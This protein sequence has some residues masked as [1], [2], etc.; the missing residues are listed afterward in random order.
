MLLPWSI[1]IDLKLFLKYSSKMW[2]IRTWEQNEK[3]FN[4]I[5]P[6][7]SEERHWAAAV[8][9]TQPGAGSECEPRTRD[10][11]QC[12]EPSRTRRRSVCWVQ[13]KGQIDLIRTA[14]DRL[15][16]GGVT[17]F[18]KPGEDH[19]VCGK[20]QQNL[21]MPRKEEPGTRFRT[22]DWLSGESPELTP[23]DLDLEPSAPCCPLGSAG[24]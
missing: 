6:L 10:H 15:N 23:D 20:N 7:S 24:F 18:P 21:V 1:R 5:L 14:S 3:Y 2:T 13:L 22:V 19:R 16:P 11:P 8:N 4:K 12:L 17:W 9:Q